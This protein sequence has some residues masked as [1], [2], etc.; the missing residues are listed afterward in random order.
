[1][2]RKLLQ[3]HERNVI[4]KNLHK[5]HL[6]HDHPEILEDTKKKKTMN[7]QTY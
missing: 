6:N 5:L 3:S 4:F 1:M 7:R 2:G